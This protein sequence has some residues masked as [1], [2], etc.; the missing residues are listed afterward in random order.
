MRIPEDSPTAPRPVFWS[1]HFSGVPEL[2]SLT[3]RGC[4]LPGYLV[5]HQHGDVHEHVMKLLDAA[6]Q[7]HDVLV[8]PLDLAEGLLRNLRV[9][10]LQRATQ[11]PT[12]SPHPGQRPPP[13]C[14]CSPALANRTEPH[15]SLPREGRAPQLPDAHPRSEDGGVS[16]LQHLLQLLICGLFAGFSTKEVEHQM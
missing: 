4:P 11:R 14:T 2:P 8:P 10:D 13:P 7:P 9:D 5:L 12:V 1:P 6:L 15:G 3:P 16:T